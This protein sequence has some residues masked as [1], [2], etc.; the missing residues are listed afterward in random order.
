MQQNG[1]IYKYIAIYVDDLPIAAKDPQSIIN[2]LINNYKF[3]LK[4]TWP[5]SFH[6]GCDFFH[7]N[8]DIL[9]MQPKKYIEEMISTYEQHFTSKPIKNVYSLLVHGNHL[10]LD[11]SKLL[12]DDKKNTASYWF[13]R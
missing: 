7:D 11:E 2:T 10:E 13:V 5:I 8:N 12:N 3:K 4:G 1:D 9:C 6:H